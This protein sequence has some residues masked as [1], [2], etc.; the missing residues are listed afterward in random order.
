MSRRRKT[1]RP[2]SYLR[3]EEIFLPRQLDIVKAIMMMGASEEDMAA[4]F[5][6]DSSLL[7]KWKEFYPALKDAIEE[8]KTY[9]DE[10]VVISLYQAAVG[11]SHEEEVLFNWMGEVI[12]A[13]RV[14]HYPPDITACKFW[15]TN[16]EKEHWKS[17]QQMAVSGGGGDASPI[18][19]R[20]ET[21]QE[22]LS[23]ILAL[24]QTKP[25]DPDPAAGSEG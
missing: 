11:Y 15:L 4:M 2:T 16:R 13:T 8:G 22:V 6:I 12:R 10:N 14:K 1:I 24:V 20:D 9:A 18:G 7:K 23:S 19:L 5:C 21:K 3:H 25:D 17:G